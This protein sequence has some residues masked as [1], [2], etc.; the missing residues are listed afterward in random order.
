[1][2]P[3]SSYINLKKFAVYNEHSYSYKAKV[4]YHSCNN[5]FFYYKSYE[6]IY[7]FQMHLKNTL[8]FKYYIFFFIKIEGK[9]LY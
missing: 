5:F 6:D 4:L 2:S 1:M 7:N 9:R 3:Q 8:N